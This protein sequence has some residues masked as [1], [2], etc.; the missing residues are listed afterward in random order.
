MAVLG[1][2]DKTEGS[3]PRAIQGCQRIDQRVAVAMQLATECSDD[4]AQAEVRHAGREFELLGARSIEEL[5][6]LVR[7]V[8]APIAVDDFLHN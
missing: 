6:N 7:D 2:A 1:V 4:V 3:R 5:E 8:M